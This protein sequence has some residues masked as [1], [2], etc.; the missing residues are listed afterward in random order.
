MKVRLILETIAALVEARQMLR[1]GSGS[2]H[3]Q[4][5]AGTRCRDAASALKV[6][7]ETECPEIKIERES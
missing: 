5:Q 4:F 2:I 6:A 3:E 1:T 7:L